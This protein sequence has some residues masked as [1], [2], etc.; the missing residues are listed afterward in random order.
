ME[1]A[2]SQEG[3]RKACRQQ[4]GVGDEVRRGEAWGSLGRRAK[5]Q[6]RARRLREG[7]RGFW[8]GRG[9]GVEQ[10]GRD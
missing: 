9:G 2:R 1:Q 7:C 10:L 5:A 4:E 8:R 6:N 3:Y